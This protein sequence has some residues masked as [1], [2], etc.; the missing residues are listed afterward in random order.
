MQGT[1]KDLNLKTGTNETELFVFHVGDQQFG[2][3]ALKI[4]ELMQFDPKG[5]TR[6]PEMPAAFL[7]TTLFRGRVVPTISLQQYLDIP[8]SKDNDR[9]IV[10]YCE[11]NS[12]TIGFT[13][14]KIVG[15]NRLSWK[16]IQAP[17]AVIDSAA[18]TGIAII[19]NQQVSILDFEYLTENILK[20][21]G[22]NID[23]ATSST[24]LDPSLS[25]FT[26]LMCDDTMVIRKKLKH[27]LEATGFRQIQIFE[28]G[29][30]LYDQLEKYQQIAKSEGKKI[31]DYV[32]LV[33]SDIEMPRMD[34]L[35][36]CKNIKSLSNE[37]PV[38]IFSSMINEQIEAQAKSVGA[39][40]CISKSDGYNLVPTI[41]HLLKVL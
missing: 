13:I 30:E 18:I 37:T 2:I 27:M 3:N 10:L 28:N 22:E 39:D 5:V 14:D 15:L 32:S 11:F 34:G 8:E 1:E 24:Q 19:D 41:K 17:S 36:L 7:G 25:K 35:T 29:Q 16:D 20:G 23:L 38:L 33:I 9:R 21:S 4:R 6:I 26:I 40:A 12:M 31:S